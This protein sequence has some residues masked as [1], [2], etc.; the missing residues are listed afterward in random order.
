MKKNLIW[1]MAL[2]V[3]AAG[4]AWAHEGEDHSATDGK[5]HSMSGEKMYACPMH[6]EVTSDKPEKCPK[7]D[8][9][10]K[11]VKVS[12]AAMSKTDKA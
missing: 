12:D 1:V 3:I 6:P 5:M 2:M 7:C 9:K 8:M 4:A 11:K 10:M